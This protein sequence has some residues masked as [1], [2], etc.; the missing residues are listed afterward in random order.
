MLALSAQHMGSLGIYMSE[1]RGEVE[2]SIAFQNLVDEF[3]CAGDVHRFGLG[4][5]YQRSA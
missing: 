3:H 4:V 1:R 2:K 5:G